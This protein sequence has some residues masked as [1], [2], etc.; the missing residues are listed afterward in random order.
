MLEEKERILSRITISFI[1]SGLCISIVLATC[2]QTNISLA[3]QSF[4]AKNY[5][6]YLDNLS[7]ELAPTQ[8][9]SPLPFDKLAMII[10]A[11]DKTQG[12]DRNTG[13]QARDL[14]TNDALATRQ[15][16][17]LHA[18]LGKDVKPIV[19]LWA[20]RKAEP[21]FPSSL[22]A[23]KTLREHGYPAAAD[24]VLTLARD[25]SPARI[26]A[27]ASI[28]DAERPL[29]D[30]Y[31]LKSYPPK[32]QN[33]QALLK[34]AV[35]LFLPPAAKNTPAAPGTPAAGSGVAAQ[36]LYRLVLLLGQDTGLL[37]CSLAQRFL[38]AGKTAEAK[39]VLLTL[40]S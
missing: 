34:L 4:D 9:G 24:V 6:G 28:P 22:A 13:V 20:D 10:V 21:D 31:M 32:G 5:A 1:I 39:A 35:D 8:S 3:K 19:A 14:L 36:K 33:R 16:A 18:L 30:A 27:W 2:A 29:I 12:W 7:N 40:V 38:Q 17:A 25:L 23:S 37:D 15:F 26:S 11:L